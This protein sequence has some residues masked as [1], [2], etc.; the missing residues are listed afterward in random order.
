M[1]KTVRLHQEE[2]M[3]LKARINKHKLLLVEQSVL[4]YSM[5]FLIK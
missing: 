3:Q 2:M 5:H 1:N 4:V